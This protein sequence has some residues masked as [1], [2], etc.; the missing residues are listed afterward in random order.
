MGW[1]KKKGRE[2]SDKSGVLPIKDPTTGIPG[3]SYVLGECIMRNSPAQFNIDCALF[4]EPPHGWGRLT[5]ARL[6]NVISPKKPHGFVSLVTLLKSHYGWDE[7]TCIVGRHLGSLWIHSH[8]DG[9]LAFAHQP[10]VV[11]VAIAKSQPKRVI[12]AGDIWGPQVEQEL[13]QHCAKD[14]LVVNQEKSL[15]ARLEVPSRAALRLLRSIF[16]TV[17]KEV[18]SPPQKELHEPVAVAATRAVAASRASPKKREMATVA[19]D[20]NTAGKCPGCLRWLVQGKCAT[21]GCTNKHY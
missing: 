15:E 7:G 18:H 8:H 9:T 6:E 17:P 12:F 16:F 1:G 13:L 3:A 2:C 4:I 10:I 20:S 14:V 11:A 5:K 19:S 21:K